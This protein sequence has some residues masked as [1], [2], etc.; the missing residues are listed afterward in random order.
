MLAVP[1]ANAGQMEVLR[2]PQDRTRLNGRLKVLLRSTTY[3]NRSCGCLT[4]LGLRVYG[5]PK[6]LPIR[7]KSERG[8]IW[9]VPGRLR[10]RRRR[11]ILPCCSAA[12]YGSKLRLRGVNVNKLSITVTT[13]KRLRSSS[14]VSF[15]F[16]AIVA[17]TIRHTPPACVLVIFD[18][19]IACPW[20]KLS[21]SHRCAVEPLSGPRG[22]SRI[23]PLDPDPTSR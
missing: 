11:G 17:H 23:H 7:P 1:R 2:R 8:Q 13:H 16:V 19:S 6:H 3:K 21:L 18:G 20:R 5:A 4:R 9:H 14:I 15:K 12:S 22:R 10:R